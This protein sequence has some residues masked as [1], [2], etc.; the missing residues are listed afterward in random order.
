MF[1]ARCLLACIFFVQSF[2]LNSSILFAADPL[3][4]PAPGQM[5]SLSASFDPLMM[6]GLSYD[7]KEPF[8]F[9]FIVRPGDKKISDTQLQHEA[10]DIVRYFLAALTLPQDDLWVNLSPYEKDRVIPQD[11]ALTG[12]GG[13]LLTQDYILKQ[14]ASSLIFPD[15]KV[16]Q[17]FW[18]KV[19]AAAMERF[20]NTD[21]PINTFNKVWIVPGESQVFVH[22]H[23]VVVTKSHLKVMM[24]E[25]YLA[26]R[27]AQSTVISS[28]QD[29]FPP[30]ELSDTV[31]RQVVLP[32][33]E[34]EVNEGSRFAT[35]RQILNAAILA[36]WYKRHLK[37]S[38]VS[39][40][41]ADQ[42]KIAGINELSIKDQIYE[43]YVKAYKKGVYNFIREDSIP[44]TQ[45]T[46]PRKYFS[47]GL[48][49]VI[50]NLDEVTDPSQLSFDSRAS[51]GS[52]GDQIID[53]GLTP[54]GDQ[55]IISSTT[56]TGSIEEF[57][58]APENQNPSWV[59]SQKRL[60]KQKEFLKDLD[61]DLIS[62]LLNGHV[63]ITEGWYRINLGPKLGYK[64]VWEGRL[65]KNNILGTPKG[66]IRYITPSELMKTSFLQVWERFK[67]L[68]P[69]VK[70]AQAFVAQWLEEELQFLS[71]WGMTGKSAGLGLELGGA[72]GLVLI[73]GIVEGADHLPW[74]ESEYLKELSE[75]DRSEVDLRVALH[76]ARQLTEKNAV[77]IDIDSP[78]PDMNTN[79]G[80]MEKYNETYLRVLTERGRGSFVWKGLQYN[81]LYERLKAVHESTNNYP[82]DQ[83]PLLEEAVRFSHEN[84]DLPMPWLGVFTGKRYDRPVDPNDPSRGTVKMGGVI[85]LNEA[86]GEGV[87]MVM[88]HFLDRTIAEGY[89]GKKVAVQAFGNVGRYTALAAAREGFIVQVINDYGISLYKEEGWTEKQLQDI[90]D[91]MNREKKSLRNLWIEN[92]PPALFLGY[93]QEKSYIPLVPDDE[94]EERIVF[95]RVMGAEVDILVPAFKEEQ[96]TIDNYGIIKAHWIF[97]G[98][99]GPTTSEADDKLAKEDKIVVPDTLTNAGGVL[100]SGL[101]MEQA[102][103]GREF[104]LAEVLEKMKETLEKAVENTLSQ[105]PDENGG[106]RS[107]FDRVGLNR[108]AAR[109]ALKASPED[110]AMTKGGIDLNTEEM[111]IDQT[112]DKDTVWTSPS[113]VPGQEDHIKGFKP[114][115]I[116]MRPVSIPLL[117]GLNSKII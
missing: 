65:A 58:A 95:E 52:T 44:G 104:T 3:D 85:G 25:D 117:L 67:E 116:D 43:Q 66:G 5:I 93:S 70:Q 26:T 102:L 63:R 48:N 47:G 72:K 75:K 54:S 113:I 69:T 106:N 30:Q 24:Q 112:G 55:A 56:P 96:I 49:V 50:K 41:Y 29:S 111:S 31:M 80:I 27:K 99:N 94:T 79:P 62:D 17:I 87:V 68:K 86:T 61:P 39:R 90:I 59:Y 40:Y 12:L 16:G 13:D 81:K 76:H 23:T 34:N 15:G 22:G 73:G 84:P 108:L 20:G 89:K 83:N 109:R 78:A 97:E 2:L 9:G 4:L 92:P 98:A 36:E 19:Y 91:A 103:Q 77:G 110:P 42:H 6:E 8:R 14:L 33:I 64:R 18:Q 45:K 10:M 88:K 28:H 35:L 7:P 37:E 107:A 1:I 82:I 21:V 60:R 74:F 51:L 46:V 11:L 100:C 32:V 71:T 53:I 38:I 105:R 101:E 114:V 115:F 57:M